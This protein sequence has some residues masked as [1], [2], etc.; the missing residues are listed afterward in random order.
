LLARSKRFF[1]LPF[2]LNFKPPLLCWLK[3][4]FIFWLAKQRNDLLFL[5]LVHDVAQYIN[6]RYKEA[7]TPL[8]GG[9]Q[10]FFLL[11]TIVEEQEEL[12]EK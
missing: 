4:H 7:G 6:I 5:I 9:A 10:P 12:N 11:F 2:F 1:S 3:T 8:L